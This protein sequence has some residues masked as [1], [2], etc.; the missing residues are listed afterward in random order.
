MKT[1]FVKIKPIIMVVIFASLL[2]PY[3]LS[4]QGAHAD[5]I[6]VSTAEELQARFSSGG[7]AKL[8][9][10]I[11]LTTDV[12]V[13]SDLNLDLN[14]HTLNISGKTLV[15][16]G[17]ALTVEDSSTE[18]S[19]KIT[20][21][22]AFTIQ[23]GNSATDGSFTLNSGTI[24]CQGSY[25]IRNWGS[26]AINGGV[27]MGNSFVVYNQG[28]AAMNGG[29]LTAL[30][31]VAV[32]NYEQGVN[33]TLNSGTVKTLGDS[34]AIILSKPGTSFVMNDGVVEAM[35]ANENG[36][37]GGNAIGAFKDTELII[38]G[39]TISAVGNT[40]TGN[41][42]VNGNSEG[43][44]AK[45]TINGGTIN[46]VKGAGIYAPQ[47]NGIT[48]ITGGTI[49][50]K[51][52]IEIR[53]GTLNISGGTINGT[54]DY[55]VTAN[56]NGL[57]TEGAAVSVAQHTTA[58]SITLNITGG[59][60]N[61]NQPI[62]STNP[63]NHGQS[64]T[65]Q[66]EIN[67]EGGEYT[68]SDLAS[69]IDNI[70]RGYTN[71][72]KDT[73][74]DTTIV[75]PINPIGYYLSAHTSGSFNIAG[76]GGTIATDY[77][78]INVL[79]NCPAGY[80]VIMT[81]TADDNNLYPSGDSTSPNF[82]APVRDGEPLI[83]TPDTWGYFVSDDATYSP[84]GS[85]PFYALPTRFSSP[86]VIKSSNGTAVNGNINDTFRVY[87]GVNLGSD[88]IKGNY[89]MARDTSGAYGSVTYQITASPSCVNLPVDVTFNQNLDA[90][91]TEGTD[92]SLQ[93]FP[94]STENIIRTDASGVTLL[95]LSDKVPVRND[96]IFV[97]WN[98]NP[99][100]TGLSYQPDGTIVVGN[101]I[102]A[103]ELIGNVTL[104]AIWTNGCAGASICYDGNGADAGT[105]PEQSARN[106]SSVM[107]TPSNFSRAGYGFAGWNTKA[108]GTGINY[109][110]EQTIT[111]P[112]AGGLMLYANWIASTGSLQ[113]WAGPDSMDIGDVIALT[114][115]RDGNTYAVAKLADGK[116]WF[117]ENLRLDPATANINIFNTHNPTPDFITNAATS[118][119][120]TNLCNSNNA[121][122]VN[123][124]SYNSNNL[125]RTLIQ[126]PESNDNTS[127]WYSYGV[128]YN[129][130]TAT[131][132]NGVYETAGSSVAGD[133]CPAGWHLPTGDNGEFVA[134]NDATK[135]GVSGDINLRTYPNN[136]IRSGDYNNK[137]TSG[138]GIQGRFWSATASD[139]NKSY[140]FGYDISSLTAN[141]TYN[142]WDAF[143]VRCVYDG[144]RIPTSEVTINF[145]EHVTSVT[146]QNNTYGTHQIT[147]SGT[148]I[149]LVDNSDYTI[150]ANFEDRYTIDAWST[151]ENGQLNAGIYSVTGPTTLSL[152]SKESVATTYTLNYDTGISTDVILPS[153][154]TSY[155]V[156]YAFDIATTIPVHFGN[157]FIGWSE[158]DGATAADYTSGGTITLTNASPD[159][160]TAISKTLYAV[161]TEDS[162][163]AGKI[164][165]FGNGA[166]AGTMSD[167]SASSNTKINL[168]PSNYS[169]SGYG[170]AGWITTEDATPYG[171][172]A[173]ITTPDLSTSGLK[174]YAKWVASAGDLQGW[175]GCDAMSQG[176]IT[177]LTDTRDG[178]TYAVAKLAD[179]KC[180][181]IE[182]LRLDPAAVSITDQ[183]TNAPTSAFIENAA[184]SSSS[185]TICSTDN[186][187]CDNK[188]QYNTN[189][190]NRTLVQSYNGTGNSV[191]WYSY[192][193]YYNWY[194]ATA[195]NGVY[196]TASGRVAGDICPAGWH[197]PTGGSSGEYRALNNAI[198]NGSTKDDTAL[199]NY[200]NN[201][202]YSGEYKNS[203]RSNGYSQAR[204]W[205]STASS[206]KQAYRVG[207][208]SGTVTAHDK[209]YNKWDGFTV[210][211]MSN[212]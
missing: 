124:V 15:P 125:N 91:G 66:V 200:P 33:F 123:T 173:T 18:Q 196:E 40:I 149:S 182:N 50:G 35:Y 168:I 140:R 183:N 24:D 25:C 203:S 12:F 207:F 146:I 167:Q 210:R 54:G 179:G 122:C 204:I 57:T 101:N 104:Y 96:Y 180:W 198:N 95:N 3:Q 81:T 6:E 17:A 43:T 163:P 212:D 132:G 82:V 46:S 47:I 131:A 10:D 30:T 88:L 27:V 60:F 28:S 148:V 134:V 70:S 116:I 170:F 205:T 59:E 92:S 143:A 49:T 13:R 130:H 147:S 211:C 16:Y 156:S 98:T 157:T 208:A 4:H 135:K 110:P 23:V 37:D 161:Y 53:A 117:I 181:M 202:I 11:T 128:Y 5:S 22:A 8:I 119:S 19:G 115:A 127:A 71:I 83:S 142:K 106:G 26:L 93:N 7:E 9:D 87:F 197:L 187:A 174:L 44:N 159:T 31:G 188:L 195:G 45:F 109:G 32:G 100:G 150:S 189:N 185:N 77:S 74:V 105:M 138:R 2:L 86:A 206:T 141:N 14:G 155:D 99:N 29:I 164:C 194:T 107:L 209:A 76:Y 1:V 61:A 38:N 113:T 67:I 97:E 186:A 144:N 63:L 193:V 137:S 21:T 192:G 153:T 55:V 52:G 184:S 80:D 175:N 112:T 158:T 136:F 69:V 166:D 84:T 145:D 36:T 176:D 162:C 103:G 154:A 65:D 118:A 20:S 68:G 79:S 78:E 177:A 178:N 171:P 172:N 120:S 133:I 169:R 108:D 34:F 102:S 201:L 39:G 75:I 41:G 165:Y 89:N 199:R 51:T 129:W 72:D 56:T 191:A 85:E 94:I 139:K 111:M 114:D 58:N 160:I 90:S 121:A 48:T 126:S 151:S 73:A 42:S 152:S 62:S 64:T 190:L